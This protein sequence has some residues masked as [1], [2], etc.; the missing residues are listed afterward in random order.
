MNGLLKPFSNF[1]TNILTR[2]LNKDF[3][4]TLP[5]AKKITEIKWFAIYDLSNQNT[6]GDIYIPEEFE[7]PSLQK[8]GSFAKRFH[9]IASDS[10]E[11][12]DSKTLRY[13][14]YNFHID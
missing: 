1:S 2:Y 6:F 13:K 3:T 10:V 9:G 5:D 11:I 12:V 7:P 8:A 14:K 4:L